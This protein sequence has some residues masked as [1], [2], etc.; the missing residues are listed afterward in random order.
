MLTGRRQDVLLETSQQLPLDPKHLTAPLLGTQD[1]PGS[2]LKANSTRILPGKAKCLAS[3]TFSAVDPCGN[4]GRLGHTACCQRGGWAPRKPSLQPPLPRHQPRELRPGNTSPSAVA[5]LLQ[6]TPATPP[7][8]PCSRSRQGQRCELQTQEGLHWP[9]QPPH[10]INRQ[11]CGR[12]S[13]TQ[14][15][16]RADERRTKWRDTEKQQLSPDS[17]SADS[18]GAQQGSRCEDRAC[19][20]GGVSCVLWAGRCS[21]AEN[22]RFTRSLPGGGS[23]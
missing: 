6:R 5:T 1:R 22:R 7:H 18:T 2:P 3:G 12:R 15:T 19:Q 16:I 14:A 21:A 11:K 20:G 23:R 10:V 9:K 13:G 4:C 17:H 8:R